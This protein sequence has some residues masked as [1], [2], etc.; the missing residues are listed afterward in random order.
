MPRT[1]A[2]LAIT[3]WGAVVAMLLAVTTSGDRHNGRARHR[4]PSAFLGLYSGHGSVHQTNYLPLREPASPRSLDAATTTP[5]SRSQAPTPQTSGLFRPTRASGASSRNLRAATV[6]RGDL[7]WRAGTCWARRPTCGPVRGAAL[8]GSWNA[9]AVREMRLRCVRRP[10][11][12]QRQRHHAN[13]VDGDVH[14][15]AA[16]L[17]ADVIAAMPT[18]TI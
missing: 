1:R 12:P 16:T 11:Q 15:D 14:S 10:G 13:V 9:V 6:G 8:R 3:H 7:P 2:R 18:A 17:V 5:T 4:R